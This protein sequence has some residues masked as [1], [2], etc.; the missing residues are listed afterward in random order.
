MANAERMDGRGPVTGMESSNRGALAARRRGGR[1]LRAAL[2]VVLLAKL[3]AAGFSYRGALAVA[4]AAAESGARA[5]TASDGGGRGVAP[6]HGATT[7][8]SAESVPAARGEA[9]A[10]APE[11]RTLLDAVTR[12]QSELDERERELTRREEKLQLFEQDVTAKLSSLEELEKRLQARAKAASAAVD[13][14]AESLAKVY[15]AMKPE[16]AAPILERL[17]E[18]TVLTIFGRMKEK[19]IGE[20]LPLMSRDKAIVLTRSLAERR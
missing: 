16:D 4:V 7:V 6:A 11:V 20:I 1:A 13:A 3:T 8:A 17:D 19:Q 12:R 5:A 18:P 15:G 9:A 2:I 14:A 10:K